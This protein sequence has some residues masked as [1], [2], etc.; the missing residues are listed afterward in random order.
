MRQDIVIGVATAVFSAAFGLDAFRQAFL[1]ATAGVLAALL[2]HLLRVAWRFVVT[3]PEDVHIELSTKL[4]A[5]LKELEAA[6]ALN[7]V[8]AERQAILD[9]IER[10][11]TDGRAYLSL[12]QNGSAIPSTRAHYDVWQRDIEVMLHESISRTDARRFGSP[13]IARQTTEH[14][15]VARR[16]E[17]QLAFLSDIERR[18]RTL[19]NEAQ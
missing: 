14:A 7:I 17:W 10:Y 8:V 18:L 16:I 4:D 1:A 11:R 15:T 3:V 9:R 19:P 5:T 13:D 6:K 12:F 2:C